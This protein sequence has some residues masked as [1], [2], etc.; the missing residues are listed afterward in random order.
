MQLNINF[1]ENLYYW[2]YYYL[3]C[4]LIINISKIMMNLINTAKVE[5]YSYSW[6][7]NGLKT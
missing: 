6:I 2:K 1:Q 7:F 4:N 5:F 3:I